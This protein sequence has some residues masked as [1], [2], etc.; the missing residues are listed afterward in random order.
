MAFYQIF[1]FKL[2]F[3]DWALKHF[4]NTIPGAR[5]KCKKRKVFVLDLNRAII[6]HLVDVDAQTVTEPM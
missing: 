3:A 4:L 1:F 2:L 6:D 5:L